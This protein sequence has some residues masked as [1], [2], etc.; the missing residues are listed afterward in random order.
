MAITRTIHTSSP[1][2]TSNCSTPP[3]PD[4]CTIRFFVQA[5]LYVLPG[6]ISS[7]QDTRNRK[8]DSRFM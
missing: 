7:M 1:V 4:Y 3:G 8:R 5:I 6:R 2:V